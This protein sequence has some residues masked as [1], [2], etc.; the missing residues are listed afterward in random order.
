MIARHILISS[1]LALVLVLV[2]VAST[3]KYQYMDLGT[4]SWSVPTLEVSR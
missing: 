3:C 4:A 2:L 1:F